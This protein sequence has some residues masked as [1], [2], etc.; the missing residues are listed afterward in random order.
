MH[1]ALRFALAA[2]LVTSLEAAPASAQTAPNAGSPSA[3]SV[4][5]SAAPGD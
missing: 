1:F 2:F 4:D 5:T 3:R